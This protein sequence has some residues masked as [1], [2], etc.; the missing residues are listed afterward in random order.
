[1]AAPETDYLFALRLQ[2]KENGAGDLDLVDTL[3]LDTHAHTPHHML[4]SLA[5]ARSLEESNQLVADDSMFA[6]NLAAAQQGLKPDDPTPQLDPEQAP[7]KGER[8]LECQ[9]CFDVFL[10]HLAF[11]SNECQHS[12]C[13]P[14]FIQYL[15]LVIQRGHPYPVTC[16]S[17]R[18]ILDN[19]TCLKSLSGTGE[20]YE[21]LERLIINK[22]YTKKI[23][24]CAN[25]K[26]AMPFD[27]VCDEVGSQD[28]EQIARVLCPFCGTETCAICR[29]VW[30]E[31]QTCEQHA[32]ALDLESLSLLTRE[33]HW[34]RCPH[35]GHLIEKRNGDCAF[36]RCTCGCGFCHTCGAAYLTL[37]ATFQNEHGTPGCNCSL[38]PP[39]QAEQAHEPPL[40]QRRLPLQLIQEDL[41]EEPAQPLNQGVIGPNGHVNVMKC[42]EDG[43]RSM[44]GPLPRAMLMSMSIN[45]C[46]YEDCDVQFRNVHALEQHLAFVQR[47]EVYLCCER[48]FYCYA[49]LHNH[50]ANNH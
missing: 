9:I 50:Q 14:C 1:M 49:S 12:F 3:R 2:L 5:L 47:H 39:I 43:G 23:R 24:Y 36:V 29:C 27:W 38:F 15:Q 33:N 6:R 34:K 44:G 42:L 20:D 11:T 17:C 31:D 25:S 32:V 19:Q 37:E 8:T 48:P 22:D 16:P 45:T 41:Q 21:A 30:H 4:H 28:V 10:P 18:L 26:C 46:P 40:P 35:C 13:Y 7:E